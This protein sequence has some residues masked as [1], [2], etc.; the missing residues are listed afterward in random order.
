MKS[1][2]IPK[3]NIGFFKKIFWALVAYP[4]WTALTLIVFDIAL[5]AFLFYKYAIVD[6]RILNVKIQPAFRYDLYQK[7]IESWEEREL[8]FNG[9][10]NE[11]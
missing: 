7:V 11:K 6:T 2:H 1:S 5:G 4:F 3:I 8:K 10:N 9:K